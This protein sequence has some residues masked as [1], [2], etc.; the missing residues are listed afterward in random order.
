MI[1]LH[2]LESNFEEKGVYKIV[3]DCLKSKPYFGTFE[4]CAKK[5]KKKKKSEK[6][7]MFFKNFFLNDQA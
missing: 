7:L 1:R 6:N 4:A 5:K 3:N 2:D